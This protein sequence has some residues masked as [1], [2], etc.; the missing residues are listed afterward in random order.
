M[1]IETNDANNGEP[2]GDAEVSSSSLEDVFETP[3]DDGLFAT[4]DFGVDEPEIDLEP[5]AGEE[6]DEGGKSEGD[7]EEAE[8]NTSKD[9]IQKPFH[10]EPRFQEIVKNQR[11]TEAALDAAN[12][13]LAEF[14][15]RD[16][17]REEARQK[18]QQ[19]ANEP[20][21]DDE[22]LADMM[23]ND[24]KGFQDL[25]TKQV[26]A[27]LKAEAEAEKVAAD[28]RTREQKAANAT[29][30]RF[31]TFFADKEELVAPMLADGSMEKFLREHPGSDPIHAFYA[32]S[33]KSRVDTAIAKERKQWEADLKAKG[34]FTPASGGGSKARSN[35]DDP[36][37]FKNPEK[38]GGVKAVLTK[39]F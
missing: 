11:E 34:R 20:E 27:N 5:G 15:A 1:T 17:A 39:Y 21:L 13:R 6:E 35:S 14:D 16:R 38:H 19:K 23:L 31:E 37:E 36:P 12:K 7:S 3:D 2:T 25:I 26:R 24:P 22:D 8:Q 28:L 32:L 18:A 4:H 9:Q 29:K 10:E 30:E 33:E